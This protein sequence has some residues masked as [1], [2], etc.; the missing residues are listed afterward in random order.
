MVEDV[1]RHLGQHCQQVEIEVGAWAR[2]HERVAD[3]PLMHNAPPPGLLAV[4]ALVSP[5]QSIPC[6]GAH[7]QVGW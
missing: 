3:E 7:G 2:G 6:K 5:R 4:K 1:W